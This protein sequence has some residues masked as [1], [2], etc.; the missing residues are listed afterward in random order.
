MSHRTSVNEDLKAGAP[1]WSV[2]QR[3]EWGKQ[4]ASGPRVQGLR[5]VGWTGQILKHKKKHSPAGIL[6]EKFETMLPKANKT[7]VSLMSIDRI[8]LSS[9]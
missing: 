4:C 2:I 7:Q 6:G 3:A 9:D 8:P 1:S 5:L